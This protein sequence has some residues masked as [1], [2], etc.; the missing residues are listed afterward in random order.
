VQ[1]EEPPP[2]PEKKEEKPV[3][4]A[5]PAPPPVPQSERPTGAGARATV[6]LA[7]YF[8]PILDALR[9]L[10][11]SGTVQDI[12]AQIALDIDRSDKAQ[13]KL[14]ASGTKQAADQ[15][16]RATAYLVRE[17]LLEPAADGAWALTERGIT[18]H[19]SH[20]EEQKIFVKMIK[21]FAEDGTLSG[22]KGS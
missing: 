15:V 11:G 8:G 18:T 19:L 13:A 22:G 16:G 1:P 9:A 2:I 3:A 17:G 7:R 4:R 12:V 6:P 21:T 10:G 5:H 14:V 20:S